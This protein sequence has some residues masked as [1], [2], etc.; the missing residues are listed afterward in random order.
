MI[1][2]RYHFLHTHTQKGFS[3][4][5]VLVY[6]AVTVLVTLAGVLTYLSLSTTLVRNE[7]E[8]AVSQSAQ[9]TLERMVRDIRGAISINAAQS[10]FGASPGKLSLVSGATTTEF[11]LVNGKV[12]LAVNGVS[13]GPLTSGGVGVDSLFF[14]RYTGTSTELVR[15]S[16]TLSASNKAASTTRTFYEGAVLRGSYE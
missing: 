4:I 10:T 5:E 2:P 1:L 11:A 6:I 12:E 9:V 13:M 14:T 7:T 15:I 3:L 8:R 16:L